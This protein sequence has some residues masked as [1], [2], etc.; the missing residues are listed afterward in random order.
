MIQKFL[1]ELLRKALLK[2]SLQA[3]LYFLDYLETLIPE[4]EERIKTYYSDKF[5]DS[6]E[7]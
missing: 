7:K 4:L 5:G 3:I 1:Q 6:E 2:S